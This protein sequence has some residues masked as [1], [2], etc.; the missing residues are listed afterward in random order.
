MSKDSSLLGRDLRAVSAINYQLYTQEVLAKLKK[1][2]GQ[3]GNK[4]QQNKILDEVDQ[5][6][7]IMSTAGN[8]VA[9]DILTESLNELRDAVNPLYPLNFQ[10]PEKIEMKVSQSVAAFKFAVSKHWQG[11]ERIGDQVQANAFSSQAFIG[12]PQVLHKSLRKKFGKKEE[13]MAGR[14]E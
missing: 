9:N 1:L 6:V 4:I 5:L 14:S 8:S 13:I 12:E 2:T 11:K 7:V 10:T 3:I